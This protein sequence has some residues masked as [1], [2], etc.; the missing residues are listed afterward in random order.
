MKLRAVI[1]DDEPYAQKLLENY[2][3]KTPNITLGAVFNNPLEALPYLQQEAVDLI[4]LDIEMPELNG[5]E[6]LNMFEGKAHIIFTTAYSNYAVESYERGAVD[7]LLKPINFDRFLK[8]VSRIPAETRENK[9]AGDSIYIRSDRRLI[10]LQYNEIFYIEGMKDYVVFRTAEKK[11]IVHNN[12]KKLEQSLPPQF[13]RI[14]YS[15][16]INFEKVIEFRENHVHIHDARIPV[17]KKYYEAFMERV[18][19]KLL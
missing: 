14:H 1:I 12:L 15:Y 18:N 17:G 8:A 6:F 10:N 16:I 13:I 7:Y 19:R 11:Y 3:L 5:M 9:P 2:I 4:F